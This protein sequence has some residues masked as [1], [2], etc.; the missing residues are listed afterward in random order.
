MNYSYGRLPQG[1]FRPEVGPAPSS[2]YVYVGNHGPLLLDGHP[3]GL[4]AVEAEGRPWPA[5]RQ[6]EMQALLC[7]L[8]EEGEGWE[9]MLRL[10]IAEPERRR[11][12]EQRLR[13]HA[14]LPVLA[15]FEFL[16][17]LDGE[18]PGSL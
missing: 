9:E 6:D 2:L 5:R 12:F 10:R 3:V 13:G 17:R 4:A 11:A 8:F 1:T 14:A 15:G 18:A 16:E 7:R